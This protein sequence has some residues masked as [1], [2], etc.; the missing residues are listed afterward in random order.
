MAFTLPTTQYRL[1][2]LSVILMLWAVQ[3]LAMLFV[4]TG[5]SIV[6]YG[7]QIYLVS[8]TV[9]TALIVL[10]RKDAVNLRK[11]QPIFAPGVIEK[12]VAPPIGFAGVSLVQTLILAPPRLDFYSTLVPRIF[13]S[14]GGI[15]EEWIFTF[16]LQALILDI[17]GLGI[18][19]TVASIIGKSLVFMFYHIRVYGTTGQI[20]YQFYGLEIT[21]AL[22]AVFASSIVLALAY[23]R[24]KKLWINQVIHAAINWMA[25]P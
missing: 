20:I 22:L 4:L 10:F 12:I 2:V 25:I 8:F 21:T 17:G 5:S 9:A 1:D 15:V 6:I 18:I 13:F 16:F 11:L 7:T 24:W 14:S 19:S 3:S 23:R